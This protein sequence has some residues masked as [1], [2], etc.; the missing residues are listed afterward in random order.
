MPSFAA[1]DAIRLMLAPAREYRARVAAA[2]DASWRRALTVPALLVLMLGLLNSTAAAGHVTASLVLDQ[3]VCWS[4]LPALQL[5]TGA[6]LIASADARRVTFPRAVEL[7]F[8]AHGPWSLWLV[9]ET[10][11][12][13]VYPDPYVVIGSGLVPLTVT[14][15]ML[16]AFGRE[17]LGLSAG[18]ARRRVIAHQVVTALMI[19]TYIELATRL[20]V[21]IIGAIAS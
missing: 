16:G 20:S 6:G 11:L 5:L 17:V 3:I 9:A 1:S 10:L 14:A 4:F 2:T 19:V 21:R 12:Q 18:R 8:A 7:L 15:F 13:T